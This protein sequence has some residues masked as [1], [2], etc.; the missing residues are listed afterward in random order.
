[1]PNINLYISLPPLSFCPN[2]PTHPPLSFCP[3]HP[4][5]PPPSPL[6]HHHLPDNATRLTICECYCFCCVLW[7]V[8]F[9]CDVGI[10]QVLSTAAVPRNLLLHAT[11]QRLLNTLIMAKFLLILLL[12]Q[13]AAFFNDLVKSLIVGQGYCVPCNY[14]CICTTDDCS[15]LLIWV[16]ICR[17]CFAYNFGHT[18]QKTNELIP[19]QERPYSLTSTLQ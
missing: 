2:H 4:T 12:I 13:K 11:R 8:I 18:C 5:H 6:H 14:T 19:S 15:I 9:M 17:I 1:M 7:R 16:W 3:N 10:T